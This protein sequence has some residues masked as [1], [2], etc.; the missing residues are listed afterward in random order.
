M[1]TR[2][3]LVVAS[4][5]VHMGVDG[6]GRPYDVVATCRRLDA[7]V[8]VLQEAWT[9]T[10]PKGPVAAGLGPVT[11]RRSAESP[12]ATTAEVLA[13]NGPGPGTAQLVADALGYSIV[14]HPLAGGRIASPHAAADVHWKSGR[15]WAAETRTLFL[16][17][18]LPISSTSARSSR[19]RTG[20]AGTWGIAVLSRVSVVDHQVIDLGRLRA[21]RARRAAVVVRVGLGSSTLAVAG[22][23]MSHLSRGSPAQLRA[24]SRELQQ[25]V[26]DEPAVLA[27]DMNCW[28]P[29]IRL[30]FPGWRRAVRGATWPAWR[31]H[32]Q[33]DHILANPGVEILGGEVLPAGG[34]DHRPVRA[35]VAVR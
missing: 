2:A 34:S 1:N 35:R 8:L 32:S 10:V 30:F 18:E 21:D 25:E 5:N 12:R 11:D 14:D 16:D 4:F 29:P 27:G 26:A 28:G 22:T 33:I 7:D 3:E 23:H 24:L 13:C 15:R 20:S 17:S 6:W 19:F 31:P 9:P